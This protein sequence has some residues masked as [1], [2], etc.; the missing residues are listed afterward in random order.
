MPRNLTPEEMENELGESLKRYRLSLNL[1]QETIAFRSGVS[2]RTLRNL[3]AGRG[4]SIRTLVVV[5]KALGRIG[6]LT[7]L[8]P[9]T[10]NPLTLPRDTDQ[11]QRASKTSKR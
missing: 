6:W 7:T 2:V 3:E 5:L 10:F 8:A 9:S 11:R 1:D 4:S